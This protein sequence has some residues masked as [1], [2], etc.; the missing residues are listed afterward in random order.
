MD[1]SE[2]N[3]LDM[4]N[5]GNW[6]LP[7]RAF[8]L[9]IVFVAVLA[10]AWH[11]NW[12][13]E[14]AEYKSLQSEEPGLWVSFED[15]QTKAVNLEAYKRNLEIL[16]GQLKDY[17]GQLPEDIE[18]DSFIRDISLSGKASYL[19]FQLIEPEAE[20]MMQDELMAGVYVLPVKI[21]VKGDYHKFGDFISRVAQLPRIITMNNFSISLSG[22]NE[23]L[24]KAVAKTYRHEKDGVKK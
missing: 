4:D 17:V 11:F 12:T 7:V 10:A 23:F 2:L 3:S 9:L 20:A 19:D 22:K 13:K 8:I 5:I 18:V 16:K 14:W 1:L 21:T 6:P 24:L 15:K